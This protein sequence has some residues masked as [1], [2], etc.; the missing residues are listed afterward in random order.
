MTQLKSKK[1]DTATQKWHE[2]ILKQ[3]METPKR[4][5]E[6]ARYLS[7]MISITLTI[8]LV[9][10]EK[11]FQ[12]SNNTTWVVIA[13]VVW[14]ISLLLTL[15][16][17]FPWRYHYAPESA[18]SVQ[19]MHDRIVRNKYRALV[20]ATALFVLALGILVAVFLGGKGS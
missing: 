19:N 6:V 17:Q 2:Y 1:A 9:G 3:Q 4:L 18:E 8:F 13:S 10:D 7:G 20:T 5:E 15:I 14:L 11:A 12:E 16:V